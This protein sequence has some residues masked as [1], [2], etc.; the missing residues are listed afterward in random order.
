MLVRVSVPDV[1]ALCVPS[2]PRPRVRVRVSASASGVAWVRRAARSR[3]SRDGRATVA[4]DARYVAGNHDTRSF[5]PFGAA[6]LPD[7]WKVDIAGTY[8]VTENL[9]LNARVENLFD[10]EYSDTWG[11]ATRG[12][13]AYIG[14]SSRW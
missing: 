14:V 7:Y 12:R 3:R 10:A 8:E 11:Y 2:G 5:P 9:M 1:R 4:A 6:E 13:T